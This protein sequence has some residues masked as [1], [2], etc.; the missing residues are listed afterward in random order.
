MEVTY[1]MQEL[2]KLPSGFTVP[3]DRVK[4]WGTAHA[5]LCCKDAIDAPFCALNGDDFYGLDA[6]QQIYGFLYKHPKEGEYAMAGFD[7]QNTLSENGYVSRGICQVN[8]NGYLDSI[9]ERLHIIPSIDGPLFTLD[10]HTY[11]RLDPES[12]VSMNMWGFTPGLLD[13]IENRFPVFYEEAIK[14]NPLKAELYLPNL[15]GELLEENLVSVKVFKSKD[16]W[17]GVTNAS[18][19][20]LV[21]KSLQELTNNGDYPNGLWK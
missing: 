3:K 13:E 19:R 4:P 6:M 9:I 17:F 16:R 8:E 20:P 21:E 2:N 7:L 5:I 10:S 12:V 18:D 1:V 14:S 15:V 11:T